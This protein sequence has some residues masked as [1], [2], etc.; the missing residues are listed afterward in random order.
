[1]DAVAGGAFLS[2]TINQATA[3]ME[4]MAFNQGWNEERTQ[5]RK[6]GGGM[7]QLKEV[8][9]LSIKI[10]LLMKRLDKRAR[11]KKKV[12]H[13]HDSRMTCEECGDTGHLGSSCLE[14]QEDVNY[15]NNN[16]NYYRPQQN[17]GWNQQQRPDYSGNYQ[18]NNSFNQPP[19]RELVLNQGKL[20]DR[21]SKKLASNDKTLE[22]INNRMDNFSTSI[23]NQ[24]SF[25]KMLESQ[26]QQ[27]A[28]IVSANQ[29]KIPGQ[30]ENL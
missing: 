3:L 21:L 4:K 15:F 23:K 22:I 20:M 9:M 6:R 30:P 13:I 2:L 19:L 26:L 11:E 28:N 29:G 7:H 17:Q 10:D 8:D 1:M 27:L 18:G 12:M 5:T 24:L 16:S 25:N 14:L